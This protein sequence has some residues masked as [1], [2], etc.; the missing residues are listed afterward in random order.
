M[1]LQGQIALKRRDQKSTHI[2]ICHACRNKRLL[3]DHLFFGKAEK[4]KGVIKPNMARERHSILAGA[5]IDGDETEVDVEFE[6]DHNNREESEDDS[7][8]GGGAEGNGGGSVEG[9]SSDEEEGSSSSDDEPSSEETESSLDESSRNEENS[10]EGV[11]EPGG[12]AK[13]LR[14]L[15]K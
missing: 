10:K 8:D 3:V 12:R 2:P 6:R 5:L 11:E 14:T 9:S 4:T 1:F 15:W 13:R 7:E